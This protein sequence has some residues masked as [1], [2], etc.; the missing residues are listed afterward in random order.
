MSYN[1]YHAHI[2]NAC[3]A[4]V[5]K[6]TNEK[7]WVV[8]WLPRGGSSAGLSGGWRSFAIDQVC[9]P[10]PVSSTEG[11]LCLAE[12]YPY[13]QHGLHAD[14]SSCRLVQCQGLRE[15][16]YLRLSRSICPPQ[17]RHDGTVLLGRDESDTLWRKS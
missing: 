5:Q 14:W 13:A 6:G 16:F 17:R 15:P 11:I 9:S 3:P 2:L 8:V 1:T 10:A 4:L 12:R 7:R